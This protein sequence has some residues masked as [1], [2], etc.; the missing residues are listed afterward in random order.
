MGVVGRQKVPMWRALTIA[1]PLAETFLARNDGAITPRPREIVA[2]AET[3]AD[4]LTTAHSK[5]FC[6][7]CKIQQLGAAS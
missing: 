1:L 4:I 5:T 7:Y 6:E 2:H 3:I